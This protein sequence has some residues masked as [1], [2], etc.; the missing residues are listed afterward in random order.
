MLLLGDCLDV[1]RG[2]DDGCIDLTVTSPPYDNLRTYNGTLNDWTPEKWKAIIA[3]LYRV[4][5]EGGVVVWVVGD[6]TVKGSETGTSFR[7]ALHATECGFRLHD[8]MIYEKQNPVPYH[9]NRYQPCFEYMFVWSKGKPESFNPIMVPSKG[10]VGGSK[11]RLADGRS[12]AFN[13]GGAV[14]PHKYRTSIWTYSVGSDRSG[15]PAVFPE[16]L[17]RDHIL[18]W[19]NEGDTVFDPFLGS[20]TTGKMALVHGRKFI[21]IERDPIYFEI[22]KKRIASCPSLNGV[23]AGS[24]Q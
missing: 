10:L 4:T 8:T 15:H 12:V 19:S 14:H 11:Q 24:D 16:C 6:A 17:A 18:S 21:G 13:S 9:H 23:P 2:M 1:I 22:A 7:Q 20:G 5:K 3:E